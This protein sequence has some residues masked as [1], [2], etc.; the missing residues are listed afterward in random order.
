MRV[1]ACNSTQHIGIIVEFISTPRSWYFKKGFCINDNMYIFTD[2]WLNSAHISLNRSYRLRTSTEVN[3]CPSWFA[4]HLNAFTMMGLLR[5]SSHFVI[6]WPALLSSVLS[7]DSKFWR[8]E[9][10]Y[11]LYRTYS[12]ILVMN[13]S[14]VSHL[15]LPPLPFQPYIYTLSEN[16][17]SYFSGAKMNIQ[18][19]WPLKVHA[20]GFA[21][22]SFLFQLLKLPL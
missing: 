5:G 1:D 3:P 15:V 9:K 14:S 20:L 11:I 13:S 16:S 21:G 12:I 7:V 18:F 19:F 17:H 4:L 8:L 10:T 2:W 22:C 6:W